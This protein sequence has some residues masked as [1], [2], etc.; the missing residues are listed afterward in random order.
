MIVAEKAAVGQ[1]IQSTG[2]GKSRLLS[3]VIESLRNGSTF[4]LLTNFVIFATS[5]FYAL[6]V[7]AVIVLRVRQPDLERPYRTWG[8][9]FVPLTFL[10]VYAWFLTQVYRTNPLEAWTG[11]LFIA[12]G[13]PAYVAYRAWIPRSAR[14]TGAT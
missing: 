2:P 6:S 7:L 1:P 4:D 3:K 12:M 8:Y 5:I 9:P 13:I 10:A 11:L 14:D